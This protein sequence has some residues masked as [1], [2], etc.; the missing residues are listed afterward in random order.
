MFL[1]LLI[2]IIF[3]FILF[4]YQ[5]ADAQM[6]IGYPRTFSLSGLI[7]LSYYDYTFQMPSVNNK[8]KLRTSFF[9]Q[10]YKITAKG[11]IYHPR[12]AVF[13]AGIKLS[14]S[15]QLAYVGGKVN[16][17]GWGYNLLL[18]FLP[19][20]PFSL[21]VFAGYNDYTTKPIGDF[22]NREFEQTQNMNDQYYGARLKISK[23]PFPLTR[24]EYQHE[25]HSQSVFISNPGTVK[26]DQFIIDIRGNLRF[27]NTSYQLYLDYF[28]YSSPNLNYKA[29]SARFNSLSTLKN[30]IFI[31]NSFAYSKI[32]FSKLLSFD[33]SL[34]LERKKAFS[35]Y[36][37]YHYL[38]SENQ[39]EGLEAQGIEGEVSK[40][41]VNSLAGAWSYRLF[42]DLIVSLSLN[43][44]HR[45][46]NNDSADFS[47][48]NASL[49]YRRSF[50]GLSFSPRYRF[51]LREDE[52]KGKLVEHNLLLDLITKKLRFGTIY[53]NY[54]FTLS[55]EKYTYKQ[56]A[57][58]TGF[59][60][61]NS[62]TSTT[63]TKI[64]IHSFRTGVRG[65]LTGKGLSKAQ[66]NIEAQIFYSDGTTERDQQQDWFSDE[67]PFFASTTEKIERKIRRYSLLVNLSYPFRSGIIFLNSG[68]SKGKSNDIS[69]EKI[70]YEG[71]VQYPVLKNLFITLKWKELWEKY[72]ETPTQR[73]DDFSL[74]SEYRIGKT[75]LSA[76][77]SILRSTTDDSEIYIKRF[78]FRYRRVI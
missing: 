35:Q 15:R 48:I 17:Q 9:E 72:A 37:S 51:I 4:G 54:S 30:G 44:G 8:N 12:L 27:W 62:E 26:T 42:S 65:S 29:K 36:Y 11:F 47:G 69:L 40:Q 55:N 77:G 59:F 34:V 5:S 58:D 74:T 18:T 14:D 6:R 10:Q 60:D 25:E 23:N 61:E 32:D 13:T 56:R 76:E 68:I 38:H 7:E 28:D 70:F 21:D 3:S 50:L 31:Y 52:L 45:K 46:E 39:F 1:F 22:I 53:A 43:Y 57:G 41:T 2:G 75:T 19:Y 16:S 71:R 20:R 33:S 78:F 66:W 64:K 73:Y 67:D 63:K 24:V 49:T